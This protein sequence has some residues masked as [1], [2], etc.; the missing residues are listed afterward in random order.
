MSRDGGQTEYRI[1][2]SQAK[3]L[4]TVYLLKKNGLCGSAVGIGK[5]LRGVSDYETNACQDMFV[6]GSLSSFSGKKCKF[7]ARSLVQHGFLTQA[8]VEAEN[9]YFLS[10]SE[11]GLKEALLELKK[12]HRFHKRTVAEPSRS[13][14][15]C[16]R[17]KHDRSQSDSVVRKL[18]V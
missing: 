16:E 8:Y 5:I 11:S 14:I 3:L 2:A 13:I 10:L 6:F 15:S 4:L 9:D 7:L 12:P 18:A 1:R 17:K